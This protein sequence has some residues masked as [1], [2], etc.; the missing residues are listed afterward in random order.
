MKIL[1]KFQKK[2]RCCGCGALLLYK[3]TDIKVWKDDNTGLMY[4]YI[5]C[6]NCKTEI[7]IPLS[8]IPKLIYDEFYKQYEKLLNNFTYVAEFGYIPKSELEKKEAEK[9][10]LEKELSAYSTVD[11]L[12]AE[13]KSEKTLEI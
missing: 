2:I 5:N 7:R 12:E 3:K 6:C 4:V 8:E 10:E 11:E 13:L 9:L 1:E